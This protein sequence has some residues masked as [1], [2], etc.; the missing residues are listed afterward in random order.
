MKRCTYVRA[1]INGMNNHEWNW[2]HII[3]MIKKMP[4]V[5]GV[6]SHTSLRSEGARDFINW[7]IFLNVNLHTT[8]CGNANFAVLATYV[9]STF[10]KRVTA[11]LANSHLISIQSSLPYSMGNEAWRGCGTYIVPKSGKNGILPEN[12]N[13]GASPRVKLG[14]RLP[15]ICANSW[16]WVCGVA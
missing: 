6:E 11:T 16:R 3:T 12:P 14:P 13:S 4:A 7:H 5:A 9:Q 10:S 2:I 8:K 1:K 15:R